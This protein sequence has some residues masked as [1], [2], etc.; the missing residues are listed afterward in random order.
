MDKIAELDE[1]TADERITE[2]A[3][4]IAQAVRDGIVESSFEV[5]KPKF[6]KTY[7]SIPVPILDDEEFV[8]VL[9]PVIGSKD[10]LLKESNRVLKS[11]GIRLLRLNFKKQQV[12]LRGMLMQAGVLVSVDAEPYVYLADMDDE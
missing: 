3:E 12:R 11:N 9:C 4:R 6:G 2:D 8:G 10:D 5:V 1:M 7:I